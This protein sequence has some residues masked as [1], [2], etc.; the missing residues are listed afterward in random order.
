METQKLGFGSFAD[1]LARLQR[2]CSIYQLYTSYSALG[3]TESETPVSQLE[4]V[5]F[6][7]VWDYNLENKF[8]AV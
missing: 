8:V 3:K 5:P 1:F 4:T 7:M 2:L 6:L